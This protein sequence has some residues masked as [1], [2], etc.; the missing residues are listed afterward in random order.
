MSRTRGASCRSSARI[1][2]A[3]AAAITAQAARTGH[4]GAVT[5]TWNGGF[6][7]WSV[8]SNWSPA[9]VPNNGGG[10]TFDVVIDSNNQVPSAV[11]LDILPTI[12]TLTLNA[13]DSINGGN[14]G[15]TIAGGSV[16]NNGWIHG[17]ATLQ[18]S[19]NFSLTG[20]GSVNFDTIGG[21]FGPTQSGFTFSNGAGQ[22][23]RGAMMMG[24]A[25]APILGTNSGRI[26][27][28][29][30]PVANTLRLRADTTSGLVNTGTLEAINSGPFLTVLQLSGKYEN[31]GGTIQ[32]DMGNSRVVLAGATVN[33]GVLSAASATSGFQA[34]AGTAVN[35]AS[36]TIASGAAGSFL[37]GSSLSAGTV[38][39]SGSGRLSLEQG[40]TVNNTSIMGTSTGTID[41][42]IGT[43]TT[44]TTVT[45]NNVSLSGQVHVGASSLTLGGTI[46][47]NAAMNIDSPGGC[48]FG[49]SSDLTLAGNGTMNFAAPVA[50]L[51]L[52]SGPSHTLTNGPGHTIAGRLF[53]GVG[54]IA[55]VNHGTITANQ[56]GASLTVNPTAFS[57]DGTMLAGNHGALL[58]RPTMG[59]TSLTYQ[60]SGAIASVGTSA[61]VSVGNGVTVAGSGSWT[62]DGGTIA[63]APNS[64]ITTTGTITIKNGGRLIADP[65]ATL[66]TSNAVN[67]DSGTVSG[68]ITGGPSSSIHSSGDSVFTAG[69]T[70]AIKA[71]ALSIASMTRLD[72]SDNDLV[73]GAATP[74][75]VIA[76]YIRQGRRGG[77]WTGDMLVSSSAAAD[78]HRATTLGLLSGAE[79]SS[80]GGNGSFSGQSYVAS[81]TLV[82][83]T[84]YGDTDLNG[85]VNFDDYVRADHGLN[86]HLTGWLNG[87][88]DG[89]GI[90]NFDDYV[91]IDLAF[92]TQS[93]TLGRA[94]SFLDGSD[95]RVDSMSDPALRRVQQHFAEF[96]GD[97]ASHFLA[98]VPEPTAVALANIALALLRP[99]RRR[100]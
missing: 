64:A 32:A 45:M 56:L 80:A 86:N 100:P 70:K 3:A 72:V 96:G 6:G 83:Y 87:D 62:A 13:G 27:A 84:Y 98:A 82:K 7:T 60:H 88:F 15:F 28:V 23:I 42:P 94:L 25:S 8:A 17:I 90:V 99:R 35:N 73:I 48:G 97:Y 49:M 76:A 51:G 66:T 71:G 34:L 24:I 53:L 81:D 59:G 37:N 50:F 63:L 68:V 30:S 18:Y 65:G 9:V 31:A 55:I 67:L 74:K 33:G 20:S 85:R 78:P 95:V 41:I 52:G 29:G 10:N 1:L 46:T 19:S 89:N 11:D 36:I 14:N 61:V 12:N 38:A 21:L 91:L 77:D 22:Q 57:N 43:V 47:N 39:M 93:G 92:N 40:V 69:A 5:A 44:G 79:Y 4:A 16:L 54:T 75:D 58:L 2:V 26:T